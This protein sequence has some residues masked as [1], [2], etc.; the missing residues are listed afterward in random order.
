ML[1]WALGA[2][3]ATYLGWA[4]RLEL[5]IGR[6]NRKVNE[7]AVALGKIPAEM[8]VAVLEGLKEHEDRERGKFDRIYE[9]LDDLKT[10]V[11][12]RG[13]TD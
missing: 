4:S 7:H 2:L 9:S 12:T 3:S 10:T 13:G 11:L 5:K 6:T 1:E 8:R